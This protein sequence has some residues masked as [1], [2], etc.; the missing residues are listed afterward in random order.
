MYRFIRSI[1]QALKPNGIFVFSCIVPPEQWHPT[2]SA[3]LIR[4]RVL[5]QEVIPVKWSSVRD[6]NKTRNQLDKAGF[7]VDDVR[8]SR[9]VSCSSGKENSQWIT[10]VERGRDDYIS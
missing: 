9:Y 1:A 8:Y 6:E 2:N 5:F 3:D 4:R 10:S 7:E